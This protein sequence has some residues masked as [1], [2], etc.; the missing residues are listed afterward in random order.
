MNIIIPIGGQGKRFADFNYNLPK[1]LI[2]SLGEPIIIRCINSLN[3]TKDDTIYIAYRTELDKYNFKDIIV[4]KFNYNFKFIPIN[5][6]TRG[7]AETVLFVLENMSPEELS[8]LSI[9]VDSDNVYNDDIIND[10][11]KIN[12][13]VIFYF[14]DENE[15]ALFSYIKIDKNTVTDIKEKVKISNYACSGAYGFKNGNLL[16]NYIHKT[17]TDNC[18]SN[19]E[20][21]ISTIYKKMLDN[22]EIITSKI[23]NN[24]ISLGT[25]QQLKMYSSN[26]D[27]D[28]KIRVCFDLDN[29]LVSY[30]KI[31]NDYTTV[32]PLIKNINYLRFLKEQGH[33]IIIY[34]A[35]RM[36]THHGN[37]GKIIQDVGSITLK[38][39][40]DFNIPYDEIYFGKPYADYYIDD[41]AIKSY[42]DLEKEL[43]FYILHPET[44]EH[45]R[46]EICDDK[47]IKYSTNIEGEKH[48]YT[49]IPK[50]I[51]NM[52]PKLIDS[53]NNSIT[54]S[55]INGIPLSHLNINNILTEKI[56]LS[57][58]DSLDKIH[59]STN[60]TSEVN[61][62]G[63]YTEKIK[64]RIESFN[65][66]GYEGLDNLIKDLN[67]FFDSYILSNSAT[68]GVIHGDPVLTN[69]LINNFDNLLFIDMRGKIND[70]LTIYGD[71][72]YDYAKVYQ[73]I[74]GYDFILMGKELDEKY[75]TNNKT[76]FEKYITKKFGDAAMENIKWITKSL[77]LSLIPI[78]NNENCKKYYNLISKIN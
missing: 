10:I 21:Y 17:I 29:T 8:N 66:S 25:P 39:L 65:F 56:L 51:E 48:W 57:I 53:N 43:G 71:I 4:K 50:G 73:S 52:F 3:V 13:N 64:K 16:K 15:N 68:V 22:G 20:F 32:E 24:Y 62:Y 12:N 40:S 14:N 54:I 55:K 74:I 69:I 60:A 61:V 58:L 45:N 75:I 11:K 26:I 33:T 67:V 27:T 78:H 37:V 2:K 6:D 36:K 77:L 42:D 30:P 41:L 19:N 63:N 28:K 18:K 38:N 7:A 23:C 70:E 9:V 5:F 47:V 44:R 34:T 49:N 76:I 46:I 59:N 35:R 31:K 72:F 1:P